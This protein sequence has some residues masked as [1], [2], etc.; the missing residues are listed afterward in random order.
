MNIPLIGV[1]KL[2]VESIRTQSKFFHL[3]CLAQLN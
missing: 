2:I 3:G 1:D